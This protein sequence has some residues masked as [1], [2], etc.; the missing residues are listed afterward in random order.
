MKGVHGARSTGRPFRPVENCPHRAGLRQPVGF[1]CRLYGPFGLHTLPLQLGL[2]AVRSDPPRAVVPGGEAADIVLQRV[3]TARAVLAA[4]L[5]T[6]LVRASLVLEWQWSWLGAWIVSTLER[7]AFV[8]VLAP[9][10]V[11]AVVALMLST[12]R[13]R[14]RRGMLRASRQPLALAA[15]TLVFAGFLLFVSTDRTDRLTPVLEWLRAVNPVPNW[16][17]GIVLVLVG[18]AFV[19]WFVVFLVCTTY[20]IQ[21]NGLSRQ[22]SL[23]LLPPLVITTVTVLLAVFGVGGDGGLDGWREVLHRLGPPLAVGAVS[24]FEI[25]LLKRRYGVDFRSPLAPPV[26]EAQPDTAGTSSV[27]DR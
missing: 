4:G 27:S 24:A 20:L 2:T 8:M 9:V 25:R 14:Q 15:G 11:F 19:F 7:G 5:I 17:L 18:T 16:L 10:A 12:A 3:L 21:R 1:A 23:P 22:R 26:A 13:P 6:L